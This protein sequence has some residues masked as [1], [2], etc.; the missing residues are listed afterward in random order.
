MEAVW[1]GGPGE[2]SGGLAAPTC[3]ED[4]VKRKNVAVT[5]A[6]EGFSSAVHAASSSHPP[7]CSGRPAF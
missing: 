5:H 6:A 1:R 2:S 3:D 7:C 4:E